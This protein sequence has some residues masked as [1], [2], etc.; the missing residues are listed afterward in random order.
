MSA[1]LGLSRDLT[2]LVAS[3]AGVVEIFSDGPSL[4]AA[5][6]SAA[7]R[8]AGADAAG[9]RVAVTRHSRTL[10]VHASIG[11]D[12]ALPVPTT[13]RR[14]AGAIR[15]FLSAARPGTQAQ[16]RVTVGYIRHPGTAGPASPPPRPGPPA[17]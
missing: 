16:V 7:A 3:V 8:L 15:D 2:A 17:R 9:A 12:S 10:A 5:A 14:V 4:H 1:D 6:A 11:V 13:V